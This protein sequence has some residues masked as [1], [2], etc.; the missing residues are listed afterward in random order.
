[1]RSESDFIANVFSKLEFQENGCTTWSACRTTAGY[2]SVR[3][4][5]KA[6]LVHR[7]VYELLERKIPDDLELDHLCRNRACVNPEHLE[8]VTHKENLSRSPITI[9]RKNSLKSECPKGHRYTQENTY[10]RPNRFNSRVCRQCAKESSRKSGI[11]F[12][13]KISNR[14]SE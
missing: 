10:R 13:M 1:M 14:E 9:G 2:G 11:K 5:G 3:N 4:W 12:R 6:F 7:L 8:P